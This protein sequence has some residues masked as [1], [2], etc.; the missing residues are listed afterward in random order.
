MRRWI[1]R[2]K[3]RLLLAVVAIFVS[4]WLVWTE[5]LRA[6]L[7]A[8]L[9]KLRDAGHPVDV[10]DLTEEPI[11]DE[12]NA[13]VVYTRA[14]ALIGVLPFAIED[15]DDEDLDE[16]DI[17]EAAKWLDSQAET[18]AMLHEAATWK[19][20][21]GVDWS[22]GLEAEIQ[23]IPQSQKITALLAAFAKKEAR[24]DRP[25]EALR[26]VGTMIR[27]ANH[28]PGSCWICYMVR[29]TLLTTAIETLRDV[30]QGR[31]FEPGLT[32][33]RIVPLVLAATDIQPAVNAMRSELAVILVSSRRW[34]AG[35]SPI[36]FLEWPGDSGAVRAVADWIA[37]SWIMRPFAIRDAMYL[38][39]EFEA[40]AQRLGNE[41]LTSIE[42]DRTAKRG[43]PYI[44][45][46]A[47]KP[48]I[49]IWAEQ[50]MAIRGHIA[51]TRAGL[52]AQIHK[53]KHGRFPEDLA[54]S[55]LDPYT[56]K[57]LLYECRDDG[58]ARVE[59]ARPIDETWNREEHEIVWELR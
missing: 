20:V 8:Q 47:T 21:L 2:R 1:W 17:T 12:Q 50:V 29:L 15:A 7:E 40:A 13:A 42:P 51:I 39:E 36:P 9:Q 45:A 48:R 34:I 27:V 16:D 53:R 54:S 5:N 35:E 25:R 52:D 38:I 28:M 22:R 30:A 37:G 41:K 11:P 24:E 31:A 59:A 33:S 19:C 49:D 10:A 44:Y 58:T 14:A 32:K 23:F 57:A 18:V 46:T 6:K 3:W 26:C 43:L 56:G 55:P 4:G